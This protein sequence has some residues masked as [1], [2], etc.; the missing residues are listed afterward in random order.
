MGVPSRGELFSD[1][2]RIDG[3]LG[4]GAAVIFFGTTSTNGA[5]TFTSFAVTQKVAAQIPEDT[6]P[7]FYAETVSSCATWQ[8][9]VGV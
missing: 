2:Y 5:E 4:R 6:L 9:K 8:Q 3:E 1:R 7:R